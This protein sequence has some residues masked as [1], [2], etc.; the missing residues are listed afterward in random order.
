[1]NR[2]G[3]LRSVRLINERVRQWPL[4]HKYE[5]KPYYQIVE[6]VEDVEEPFPE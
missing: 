4:R 3:I 5:Y 2:D 1:M 6:R